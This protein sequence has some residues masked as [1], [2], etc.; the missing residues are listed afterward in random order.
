MHLF[1]IL[2]IWGLCP[3]LL[4]TIA[5]LQHINPCNFFQNSV[6]L[7]QVFIKYNRP[8]Q[9]LNLCAT[10]YGSLDEVFVGYVTL[11][12]KWISSLLLRWLLVLNFMSPSWQII[13]YSQLNICKMLLNKYNRDKNIL[14]QHKLSIRI[15]Y[16]YI[17]ATIGFSVKTTSWC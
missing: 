8:I 15:P 6:D 17:Y 12:P 2:L 9:K 4:T 10:M 16:I 11:H 13:L 14:F 5:L 1:A 3:P 7:S